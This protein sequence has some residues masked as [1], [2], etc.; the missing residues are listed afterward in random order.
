MWL[1]KMVDLLIPILPV[2]VWKDRLIQWHVP[3]CAACSRKLAAREEAIAVLVQERELVSV[4][5]FWPVVSHR[6]RSGVKR[7]ARPSRQAWQWVSV[8]LVLAVMAMTN[9]WLNRAPFEEASADL[10][11]KLQIDYIRIG[12]EPARAYVFQPQGVNMTL[13]WIEKN[14]E[15]E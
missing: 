2:S 10:T 11:Q 4:K 14:G 3:G 5:D 12:D 1:C 7:E 9:I 13:V 8:A 6:L 15:G